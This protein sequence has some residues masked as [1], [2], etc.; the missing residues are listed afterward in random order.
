MLAEGNMSLPLDNDSPERVKIFACLVIIF[1][2]LS[3][4]LGFSK[5]KLKYLRKQL[6][7]VSCVPLIYAVWRYI[8]VTW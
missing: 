6:F 3:F 7:W 2:F 4:I 5:H 8:H 1:V